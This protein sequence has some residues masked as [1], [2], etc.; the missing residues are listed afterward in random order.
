MNLGV[1]ER[2]LVNELKFVREKLVAYKQNYICYDN[3]VF[4]MLRRIVMVLGFF[5]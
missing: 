3:M 5:E 2:V 4:I 1:I